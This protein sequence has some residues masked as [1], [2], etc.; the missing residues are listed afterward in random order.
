MLMLLFRLRAMIDAWPLTDAP[1]ARGG[2]SCALWALRLILR[3]GRAWE[4]A[5]PSVTA[6]C[7]ATT[8]KALPNLPSAAWLAVAA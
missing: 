6:R 8:S 1:V 5:V 4:K 3:A 7:F 2:G